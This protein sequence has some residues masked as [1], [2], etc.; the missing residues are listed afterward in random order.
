M[1]NLITRAGWETRLAAGA[2]RLDATSGP[3]R[4]TVN[5]L[6]DYLLFLDEAPLTA[7]ITGTSGFADIFAAQGP[8]D[9]RGRSLKQLDLERRLLRYPCSYM[10]YSPAFRAL[11]TDLR[12]AIYGRMWAILSGRDTRTKNAR[13]SGVDRRAIVDLLRATLPDLPAEFGAS[14]P[15][16]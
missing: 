4:E 6:V 1:T 5:E 3:L 15:L 12:Q 16:D 13:L 9:G 10:I 11:P 2:G 14:D 7:A 8:V